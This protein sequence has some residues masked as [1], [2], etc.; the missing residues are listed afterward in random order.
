M[1]ESTWMDILGV[2]H[3]KLLVLISILFVNFELDFE[4]VLVVRLVGREVSF[5]IEG[6]RPGIFQILLFSLSGFFWSGL[7]LFVGRFDFKHFYEGQ[8]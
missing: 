7:G 5:G 4:V 1:D 6:K 2:E 3:D 8:S